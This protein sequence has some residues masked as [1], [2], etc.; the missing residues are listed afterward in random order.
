[1]TARKPRSTTLASIERD[2]EACAHAEARARADVELA[3]ERL[4]SLQASIPMDARATVEAGRALNEARECLTH[5]V[6]RHEHVQAERHYLTGKVHQ[7]RAAAAAAANAAAQLLR[8]ISDADGHDLC[9]DPVGARTPAEFMAALRRYRIWAGEPSFRE[10][11]RLCR[12]KIGASTL[13]TA[14]GS[15]KMPRLPVVLAVITGCG[16]SEEDQKQFATAW[17]ELRFAQESGA[18]QA[19]P[20]PRAL[21][22]VSAAS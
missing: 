11:A 1:V 15:D 22:P 5:A 18:Q 21:R 13:C 14:L 10:M 3:Q 8:T 20:P 7:A 17:R 2:L 9:P 12:R 19:L 4:Q 16:G 6:T